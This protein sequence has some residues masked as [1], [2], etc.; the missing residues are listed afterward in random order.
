MLM[1][2]TSFQSSLV[3]C[4]LPINI[5]LPA[6]EDIFPA[7]TAVEFRGELATDTVAWRGCNQTSFACAFY[8]LLWARGLIKLALLVLFAVCFLG[9]GAER[10]ISAH[11]H[12]A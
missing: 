12:C 2:A 4:S 1:P 10:H 11:C 7:R 3:H 6:L 9:A 5:L 8:R